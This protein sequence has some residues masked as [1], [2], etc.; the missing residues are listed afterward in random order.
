MADTAMTLLDGHQ[1]IEAGFDDVFVCSVCM[2]VCA[3]DDE[4]YGNQGHVSCYEI[5]ES[6]ILDEYP[7]EPIYGWKYDRSFATGDGKIS[8]MPKSHVDLL[9]EIEDDIHRMRQE[10]ADYAEE[11]AKQKQ[12]MRDRLT[13]KADYLEGLILEEIGTD[14][15]FHGIWRPKLDLA[16]QVNRDVDEN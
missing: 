3:T 15:I 1:Y 10:M 5:I 6:G 11:V 8:L 14:N 7:G 9:E 16:R 2:Y 13:D 4:Y 12:F